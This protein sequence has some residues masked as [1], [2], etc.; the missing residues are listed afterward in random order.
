MIKDFQ[1]RQ[2]GVD[3]LT[4]IPTLKIVQKKDSYRSISLELRCK[5]QWQNI[6]K[7]NTTICK[8]NCIPWPIWVIQHSKINHI[9][10]L[11]KKKHVIISNEE[12]KFWQI[13]THID[14]KKIFGNLVIEVNYLSLRVSKKSITNI[15]IRDRTPYF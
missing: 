10:K 1:S 3:P 9:A 7:F 2:N 13:L 14:D 15:I 6:I 11:K 8:K 4:L 12:K 5:K